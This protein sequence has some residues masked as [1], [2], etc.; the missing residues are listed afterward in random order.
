MNLDFNNL[1]DQV[2]NPEDVS[3]MFDP[4]DAQQNKVIAILATIP[5]LCWL[6]LVA[7]PTSNFAKFYGN[8]SLL[9]FITMIVLGIV[10]GV[11]GA[12]VG[13]IPLLGAIIAGVL[14][15]AYYIIEL[16]AWVFLVV[17]AA[18]GKAKYLPI[19]GKMATIIK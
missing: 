16:A 14:N 2:T 12:I 5:I 9:M 7:A 11:A 8:Q 13:L 17:G 15:A 3:D 10:V 19:V 18:Q 1:K 6:P 4:A